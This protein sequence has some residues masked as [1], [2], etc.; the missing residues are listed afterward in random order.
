M[1]FHEWDLESGEEVRGWQSNP[2]PRMPRSFA[3][4]PNERWFVAADGDGMGRV[5]D[6]T[7]NHEWSVDFDLRR[8]SALVFSPDGSLLAAVS[9]SGKGGI[10]D[11]QSAQRIAT[12]QGFVLGMTSA[13]FSPNGKRL[14]IGSNGNEAVKIWDVEG[15]HELLTLRGEGSLFVRSP[16]PRMATRSR[17]PMPTA[18]S[19][20]GTRLP[21]LK[22]ST[23]IRP[24]AGQ[25]AN[26]TFAPPL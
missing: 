17:Q 15:V 22:S 24:R 13:A 21:P 6:M 9:D 11:T 1:A 14:A 20:S 25:P 23:R 19:T 5:R 26:A 8:L 16:S 18:S 3:F 7:A 10:W 12:L 4:S 2:L